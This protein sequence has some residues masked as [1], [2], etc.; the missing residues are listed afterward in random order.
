MQQIKFDEKDTLKALLDK[1]KTTI[2][3][4]AWNLKAMSN[5]FIIEKP[6]KY[7]VNETVELC[8]TGDCDFRWL[9]EEFCTKEILRASHSFGKAKI[10]SIEKIEIGKN[11]IKTS[12]NNYLFSTCN[13][14]VTDLV[15]SEGFS[16]VEEMFK[17]LEKYLN[18]NTSPKPCWL[19]RWRY[20]E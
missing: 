18:L 13:V 7:K 16:S 19:I 5:G 2:L 11:V 3:R 1:T 17:F 20:L 12:D 6:C 9:P 14:Y 8:W 4:R 15:K 10:T